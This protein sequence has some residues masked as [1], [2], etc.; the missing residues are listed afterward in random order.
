MYLLGVFIGS[1][2]EAISG[3]HT[4][5]QGVTWRGT[6]VPGVATSMPPPT[7]KYAYVIV[8]VSYIE[9]NSSMYNDVVNCYLILYVNI[10]F[11]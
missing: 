2:A 7:H 1:K 5:G 8:F 4:A 3:V 9:E 11:R 10:L 6:V